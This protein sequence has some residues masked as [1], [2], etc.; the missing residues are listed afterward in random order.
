MGAALAVSGANAQAGIEIAIVHLFFNLSAAIL[1]YPVERIRQLPLQAAR[2]LAAVAV[3]S[4][5]VA[6]LYVATMFYCFPILLIYLT[7]FFE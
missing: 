3:K 7:K 6:V 1:I 5:K 2:I 4:R